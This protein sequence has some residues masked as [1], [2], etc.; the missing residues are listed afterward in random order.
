MFFNLNQ[1][2]T[3]KPKNGVNKKLMMSVQYKGIVDMESIKKRSNFNSS[4]I[5]KS[6]IPMF[7]LLM[8]FL[9]HIL[10]QKILL[11]RLSKATNKL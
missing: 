4:T 9:I 6:Q 3:I 11:W 2:I 8:E 5:L 10:T 1:R 7:I